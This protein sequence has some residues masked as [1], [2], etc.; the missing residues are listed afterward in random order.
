[1]REMESQERGRGRGRILNR[2]GIAVQSEHLDSRHTGH[3]VA[4]TTA[5]R[6]T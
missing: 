6:S 1:M 3:L 2:R 5:R 4:Y